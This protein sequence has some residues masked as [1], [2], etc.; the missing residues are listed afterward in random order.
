LRL[1]LRHHSAT[2]A[3]H[4]VVRWLWAIPSTCEASALAIRTKGL[5]LIA[6]LLATTTGVTASLGAIGEVTLPFLSIS[7]VV[8]RVVVAVA[9]ILRPLVVLVRWRGLINGLGTL[10]LLELSRGLHQPSFSTR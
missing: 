7:T 8:L 10:G 1:W 5:L 6:F 9:L 3:R 2:L 4:L